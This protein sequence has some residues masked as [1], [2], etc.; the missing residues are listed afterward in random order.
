MQNELGKDIDYSMI[1]FKYPALTDATG[2]Y[3]SFIYQFSEESLKKL[4]A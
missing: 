2:L 3:K 4:T 1:E